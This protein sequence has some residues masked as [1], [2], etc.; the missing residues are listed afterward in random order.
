LHIAFGVGFCLLYATFSFGMAYMLH[1]SG[2]L[3]DKPRYK[4]LPSDWGKTVLTPDEREKK[5][6]GYAAAAFLGTGVL[7]KHFDREGNLRLFIPSQEQIEERERAAIIYSDVHY[8]AK[9]RLFE[10]ILWMLAPLLSVWYGF[11]VVRAKR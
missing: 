7:Y 1:Q 11:W 5:S 6:V 8:F 3:L 10:G 2:E 9:A 4:Q